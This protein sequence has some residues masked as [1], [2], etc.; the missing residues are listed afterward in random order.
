MC[1]VELN[2]FTIANFMKMCCH[3]IIPLHNSN[4]EVEYSL[5]LLSVLSSKKQQNSLDYSECLTFVVGVNASLLVLMCMCT[6]VH[7]IVN[8]EISLI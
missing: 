7:Y 1:I 2:N 6:H 5:I 4:A 3:N 8:I